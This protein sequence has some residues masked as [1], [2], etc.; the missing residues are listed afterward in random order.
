MWALWSLVGQGEMISK[1]ETRYDINGWAYDEAFK[2]EHQFV[3]G[4]ERADAWEAMMIIRRT[5]NEGPGT[6]LLHRENG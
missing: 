6:A 2:S 4:I 1:D 5:L 3:Y